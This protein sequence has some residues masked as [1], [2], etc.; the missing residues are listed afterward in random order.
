MKVPLRRRSQKRNAKF[1]ESLP[2]ARSQERERG[3]ARVCRERRCNTSTTIGGRLSLQP[4]DFD[5]GLPR[6]ARVASAQHEPIC[7]VLSSSGGDDEPA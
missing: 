1:R 6:R 2:L 3:Q 7:S 4:L 5:V